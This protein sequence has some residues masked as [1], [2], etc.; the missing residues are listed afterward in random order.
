MDGEEGACIYWGVGRVWGEYREGCVVREYGGED[1]GE[2]GGGSMEGGWR[3]G[4]RRCIGRCI[5]G[6]EVLYRC[7]EGLERV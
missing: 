2:G 4:W 3:G 5:E 7:I 6:L 1:G